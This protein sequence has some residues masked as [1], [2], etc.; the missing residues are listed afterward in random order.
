MKKI[1][2]EIL[3][4]AIVLLIAIG[5]IYAIDLNRMKHNKKV[6]FSTWGRDYAPAEVIVQE[7]PHYYSENY[8]NDS[9]TKIEDLPQDYSYIQAIQD[10][11]IISM[12]GI[13]LFNKSELD[14]FLDKVN[15]NEPYS[16]R[17]ISYTVEGDMIITDVDYKGNNEFSVC[18]DNTRDRFSS[19]ED[20]TYKYCKFSKIV[21]EEEKDGWN[22][23]FLTEKIDGDLDECLI[24]Y[25]KDDANV[26]NNY[27]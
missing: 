7:N 9:K 5:I 2:K 18:H 3:I 23:Y 25:F 1:L 10:K 8:N 22:R 6:L 17:C 21:I 15:K 11:C 4:T 19:K 20:R 26:I 12:Q 16:I 14:K 27:D 13:K 24:T